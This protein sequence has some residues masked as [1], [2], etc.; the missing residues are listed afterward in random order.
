MV[1]TDGLQSFGREYVRQLRDGSLAW[2][3]AVMSG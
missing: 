2:L 3:D 1:E